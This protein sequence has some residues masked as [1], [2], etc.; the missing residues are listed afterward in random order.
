MSSS[1]RLS[2]S[3]L[4]LF[5]VGVFLLVVFCVFLFVFRSL[6][7]VFFFVYVVFMM[8]LLCCFFLFFNVTPPT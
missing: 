8:F 2:S 6:S 5:A 3:V 4:V 7:T 1:S